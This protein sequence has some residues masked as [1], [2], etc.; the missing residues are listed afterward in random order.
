MKVFKDTKYQNIDCRTDE[1]KILGDQIAFGL[2]SKQTRGFQRERVL[3]RV[4]HLTFCCDLSQ[5][6]KKK[7]LAHE[8]TANNEK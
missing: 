2:Q 1:L 4:P 8:V 5:L 6:N 7:I 3:P